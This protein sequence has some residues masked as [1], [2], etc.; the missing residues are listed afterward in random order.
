MR[1]ASIAPKDRTVKREVY[2]AMDSILRLNARVAQPILDRVYLDS[3]LYG[4][5]TIDYAEIQRLID[6]EIARI[7]AKKTRRK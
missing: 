6:A 1:T 3:V 7:Q 4:S 5:A 2:K